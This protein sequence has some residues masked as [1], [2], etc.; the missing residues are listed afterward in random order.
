MSES[1]SPFHNYSDNVNASTSREIYENENEVLVF[2]FTL[3]NGSDVDF[4][5]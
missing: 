5:M 2:L 1:K 3:S 4:V